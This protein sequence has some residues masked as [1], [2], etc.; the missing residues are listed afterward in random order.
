MQNVKMCIFSFSSSVYLNLH[1]ERLP[2]LGLFTLFTRENVMHV[3][4]F[5]AA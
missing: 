4:Q 1:T 2:F 3:Q 5:L